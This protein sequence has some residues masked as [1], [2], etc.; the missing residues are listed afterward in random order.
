MPNIIHSQIIDNIKPIIWYGKS[1]YGKYKQIIQILERDIG[2][3]VQYLLLEPEV[4]KEALE[5][6]AEALWYSDKFTKLKPLSSYSEKIQKRLLEQLDAKINKVLALAQT[7]K[8]STNEDQREFA[9]FLE[10]VVEVPS[11]DYVYSNG[12]NISLACWGFKSIEVEDRDFKLS[13]VIKSEEVK[14]TIQM[15]EGEEKQE[16]PSI[17]QKKS[18]KYIYGLI[19]FIV[20]V[21]L[22][23]L[24]YYYKDRLIGY[25]QDVKPIDPTVVKVDEND[26]SKRK[27]ITNRLTIMLNTEQGATSQ[28]FKELLKN[29][30]PNIK[31][32]YEESLIGLIEVEISSKKPTEWI[33]KLKKLQGVMTVQVETVSQSSYQPNDTGFNEK[34][35]QWL[36]EVTNTYA[37]WEKSKGDKDIVIAVID[38]AF[39]L[40]HP[41]L[42][43][44]NIVKP[45]NAATGTPQ[46]TKATP[47]G[48]LHGTHV[49][50]TATG[51]I[52]NS[53]GTGGICPNCS[54]MPIQ[55]GQENMEEFS[56]NTVL[57]AIMYAIKNDADVIN[58]SIGTSYDVDFSKLSERDKKEMRNQKRRETLLQEI[59]YDR[60]YKLARE[61]NIAIVYAAGNDNMY[62]DIDPQKR[63]ADIIVVGAVK[64]TIDKSSFSNYGENV[65]VSAPG[66]QIYSAAPNKQYKY[67][68]GTSMA[69][70]IVAGLIGLMKSKNPSLPNDKIHEILISTAKEI[71]NQSKSKIGPMIQVDKALT[72]A[73]KSYSCADELKKIKRELKE[74]KGAK[75]KKKK[76]VEKKKMLIPKKKPKNFTFAEGIWMSDSNLTSES[77]ESNQIV[78][79]FDIKKTGEGQITLKVSKNS[80]TCKAKINLSFSGNIL[81]INQLERAECDKTRTAYNKYFFKCVATE[82]DVALCKAKGNNT[83]SFELIKQDTI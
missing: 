80:E 23:A 68:D 61:K 3:D 82:E 72:E 52:D 18:S 76:S 77:D 75:N 70:P 22:L 48:Y 49:A 29:K 36:F 81:M 1:V 71:N 63:S 46:L 79:F 40:T 47:K 38:G 44:K 13:K 69:S 24:L 19:G 9:E 7:M 67:L 26:T 6:K 57:R 51:K 28:E 8:N 56:S 21:L 73:L 66:T 50:T 4:S 12:K 64:N 37:G 41:E 32:V 42:K 16:K 11:L 59:K 2:V 27:I 53:A 58:L 78:L 30:Y 55:I 35:K 25:H 17:K 33:E 74:C 60:V 83:F 39:D 14:D 45:W 5:G 62:S 65:T 31:I 20:V 15:D 43:D 10:L 34:K 54:L